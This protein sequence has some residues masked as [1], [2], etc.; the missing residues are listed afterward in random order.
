MGPGCPERFDPEFVKWIWNFNRENRVRNY[1]WLAQARHAR[2]LV[3]KNR[4][5]VNAFLASL[6]RP[7]P[8]P[9]PRRPRRGKRRY[10]IS[11]I[12][13]GIPF[14]DDFEINSGDRL[15]ETC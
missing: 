5:E 8:V 4:K 13:C 1:T 12:R 10:E 2:T 6:P 9:A 7:G 14:G 15:S 3:L 11:E